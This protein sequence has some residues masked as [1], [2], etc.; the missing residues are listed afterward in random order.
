MIPAA[1]LSSLL[2]PLMSLT[3][4]RRML[5][6]VKT[7]APIIVTASLILCGY[8]ATAASSQTS[9]TVKLITDHGCVRDWST[10]TN[11]LLMDERDEKGV[12]Q[13]Y[14]LN[15][16]GSDVQA[17]TANA[18]TGAPA[19]NRHK[20]FAHFDSRGRHIVMEAELAESLV[21][22]SS[23][24]QTADGRHWTNL[25]KFTTQKLTGACHLTSRPTAGASSMHN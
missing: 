5:R 24:V 25:T 14:T 12:Y 15:A 10:L 1:D 22:N 20:G 13:V 16:D 3:D 6:A 23:R 4:A 8:P 9:P 2:K 11:K 19:T 17:I 21:G 7:I 18:G